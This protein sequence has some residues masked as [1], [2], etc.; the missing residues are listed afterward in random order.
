MSEGILSRW[1]AVRQMLST[2]ADDAGYLSLQ[3]YYADRGGEQV[4]RFDVTSDFIA[5]WLPTTA[6]GD[7][8]TIDFNLGTVTTDNDSDDAPEEEEQESEESNEDSEDSE[9]E[10]NAKAESEDSDD[11]PD[12]DEPVAPIDPIDPIDSVDLLNAARRW[13][14]ETC[15]DN[16]PDGETQRFRLRIHSDRG[17]K[18]LWSGILDYESGKEKPREVREPIELTTFERGP[19]SPFEEDEEVD[20]TLDFTDPPSPDERLLSDEEIAFSELLMEHHE[21]DDLLDFTNELPTPSSPRT[22]TDEVFGG[23]SPFTSAAVETTPA[24]TVVKRRPSQRKK[25]PKGPSTP[26]GAP[27]QAIQS[28]MH[29]HKSH[30]EFIDTVLATTKQLVK[31][32]ASAMDQLAGT[33]G[34]ARNR[35]NDL[36]KVVQG[37]RIAEAESAVDA[38]KAQDSS[39]VRSV[40]GKEAIA[41]MGLLGQVLLTRNQQMQEN[42]NN[43]QSPS[44]GRGHVP[45]ATLPQQQEAPQLQ[46]PTPNNGADL[47]PD[48]S[49]GVTLEDDQEVDEQKL[50]ELLGWAQAR[51]DVL[52]ALTDPSV[53]NYLRSPEQVDQLRNLAQMFSPATL[54][55]S[56]SSPQIPPDLQGGAEATPER[57]L[58]PETLESSV[59]EDIT[60]NEQE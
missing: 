53:R 2:Y 19:V 59:E 41:Q 27:S 22:Y 15:E 34:D 14:Y 40:L 28:L 50:I 10:V 39:Q 25:D 21:D 26:K 45:Q 20:A 31:V 57:A 43:Q 18:Q 29:L 33:L 44:N 32:Q 52:E 1:P 35:E 4:G 9:D 7:G 51:P 30:K 47:Y 11:T 38:A 12:S 46:R 60:D 49:D 56:P 37:L 3:T 58:N 55:T 36:V 8:G 24:P 5:R 42:Q 17:K 16:T 48:V 54:D 6:A 13:L 23:D